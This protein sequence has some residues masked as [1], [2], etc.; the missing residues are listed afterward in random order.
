MT[1]DSSARDWTPDQAVERPRDLIDLA[2]VA[3]FEQ[4]ALGRCPQ[5]VLRLVKRTTGNE[6]D[7][8]LVGLVPPTDC[9]GDVGPDRIDRANELKPRRPTLEAVP[10]EDLRVNSIAE[11]D[12][13]AVSLK[14]SK[15]ATA[16]QRTRAVATILA[17]VNCQLSTVN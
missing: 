3:A 5:P 7:P 15:R 16:H 1:V 11:R 17:P 10:T 2:R 4:P 13:V 14:V 8:T 9:L 6:E 12:S